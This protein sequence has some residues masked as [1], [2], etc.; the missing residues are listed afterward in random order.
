MDRLMQVGMPT[1][2]DA[3]VVGAGPAGSTV[4]IQ[5]ARAGWAVALIE[6][7]QFPRR[8]VCGECIAA[9]NLPLLETL[10]IADTFD[11]LAGADLRQVTLL[12]GEDAV[13]ADLPSSDHARYPWGRALGRESLDSLLLEQARA[14]GGAL[15]DVDPE[16]AGVF[17]GTGMGGTLTMDGGYQTLYGEQSDRIKPFTILM[18]MHNAAAAWIGIEHGLRGPN[19][20]YSTACS[21]STVAIGEAWMRVA[22]GQLDVAIAGGPRRRCRPAR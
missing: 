1:R 10:G 7:Q 21:S 2:F 6:R 22:C 4:A 8:K 16:R 18:G 14:A 19:M 15:A 5:L 3:V 9:S 11:A 13:T 20:T 12:R 17:V